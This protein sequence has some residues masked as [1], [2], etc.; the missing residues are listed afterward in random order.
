MDDPQEI[1]RRLPA[2][3]LQKASRI[4]RDVH[5]LVVLV[6][7]HRWRRETLDQLEMELAQRNTLLASHKLCRGRADI[8]LLP[9]KSAPWQHRSA[10][11]SFLR[12]E[13]AQ[14]RAGFGRD[15]K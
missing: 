4:F 2:A 14:E 13:G 5:D 7:H 10:T 11:R 8:A 1:H 9:D 15:R 12:L 3:E 6:H